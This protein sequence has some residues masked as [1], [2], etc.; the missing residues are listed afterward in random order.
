M[1]NDKVLF[2]FWTQHPTQLTTWL[3]V[4]SSTRG[5]DLTGLSPT[6]QSVLTQ[7]LC[8]SH[9]AIWLSHHP[10]GTGEHFQ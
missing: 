9:R 4:L 5:P 10:R 1:K 2:Y 7:D 8:E 6:H 3:A